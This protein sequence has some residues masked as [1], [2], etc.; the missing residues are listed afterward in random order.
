MSE[1]VILSTARTASARAWKD[2]GG[3]Q[4]TVALL[5]IA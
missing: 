3:G 4:A 5:E 2:V 1:V